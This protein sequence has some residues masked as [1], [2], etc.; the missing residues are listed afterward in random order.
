MSKISHQEYRATTA[1]SSLALKIMFKLGSK[2]KSEPP[3][4][5]RI[6]AS[7]TKLECLSIV[8]RNSVQKCGSRSSSSLSF[9]EKNQPFQLTSNFVDTTPRFAN[10]AKYWKKHLLVNACYRGPRAHVLLI[11][12]RKG[13]SFPSRLAE[14]YETGSFRKKYLSG[15]GTTSADKPVQ[16]N[17]PVLVPIP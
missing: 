10:Q 16:V 8:C 14:A 7:T 12:Y 11:T 9:M 13:S 4:E 2:I 3:K 5:S 6:S 1:A 17:L 15:V